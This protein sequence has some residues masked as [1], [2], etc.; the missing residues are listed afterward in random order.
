MNGG[1]SWHSM[2]SVAD[3]Q[4]VVHILTATL[5]DIQNNNYDG[6]KANSMAS[7]FEKYTFMKSQSKE[8]YLRIIKLKIAQ[9]RGQM[10]Q[11][12]VQNSMPMN[13]FNQ[14]PQQPQ[15][16]QA[17]QQSQPQS[18]PPP[19]P[20][21]AQPPPPQGQ[22]GVN[23]GSGNPPSQQTIQQI[24]AM[25][26]TAPIP[27]ALLAKIP[28]LPPNTNTWN[29][30]F[31]CIN[32]KLIPPSAMGAIKEIHNTHLQVA[33]RQHHQR[34]LQPQNQ[35]Q[36]NMN[37]MNMN[38]MNMNNMNNMNMN[39]NMGMNN[40]GMDNNVGGFNI[41]NLTPQQ[42]QQL[43]QRQ[44]KNQSISQPQPQPQPQQQSQP[45]PPHQPQTAPPQPHIQNQNRQFPMAQPSAPIPGQ[46]NTPKPPNFTISPQ[47]ILKYSGEAMM[48]LD[49]LQANGSIQSV[50]DQAQKESFIRKFIMH[51]KTQQWK[52]QNGQITKPQQG[53][54]R[55][56]NNQM[57]GQRPSMNL[58][59]QQMQQM[60][61]QRAQAQAQAQQR[62]IPPNN[63]PNMGQIPQQLPMMNNMNVNPS[64]VMGQ[65]PTMATNGNQMNINRP[66]SVNNG[67]NTGSIASLLP[68]LT[69]DMRLKLRQ[70]IEEVSRNNV[71]LKEVSNLLSQAD[72]NTVRET[73]IKISQ[74]YGN[75]DSIISYFYI[76]TKNIE[77][78]KRLIQMKYMT[79]NIMEGL[80]RGSFLAS[81][82]LA[83][84]LRIQYMKYFDYV[85]E[86][87]SMR[88]QQL[89]QQ[90]PLTS[91]QAPP[92]QM[93]GQS[94]PMQQM[95]QNVV[96]MQN[97]FKPQQQTQS[98]PPQSGHPGFNPMVNQ[99]QWA[100]VPGNVNGVNGPN[101]GPIPV[102]Q[103]LTAP[104]PQP[105][106]NSPL[107]NNNS[108]PIMGLGAPRGKGKRAST[109]AQAG[110]RK[111]NKGGAPTPGALATTP[112]SLANAIKTPNSIPTP[113]VPTGQSNKNT[114]SDQS[115]NYQNKIVNGKLNENAI[116]DIFSSS[117]QNESQD[118][119]LN[120]RRELS[121]QDPEKF[122]FASLSNL[123]E[124]EDGNE[125][126]GLP[127]PSPSLNGKAN[128][129]SPSNE[130]TA[131]IKPEAI[132][133]SF[134][135]VS[136]IKEAVSLDILQACGMS[137]KGVK[138][139]VNGTVKREREDD[140]DLDLLFS[141]KKPK[142]EV[143]SEIDIKPEFDIKSDFGFLA[144]ENID[145][146]MWKDQIIN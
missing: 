65:R 136:S 61:A 83:E 88:R 62:R 115:P 4:K 76:L 138:T 111:S 2:Y 121:N 49:K 63:A 113:Q 29:Q 3:R 8:E 56:G 110:R 27:P 47:D 67:N 33:L 32:K 135:Q 26:R 57:N 90:G 23:N 109:S 1:S 45:Q 79:K 146:A 9:L 50:L 31:D 93:G 102:T 20:T 127:T 35:G 140:D 141:D 17:P 12:M 16:G 75:V 80:Q 28:N 13:S 77:G 37:N 130:W 89:Q 69:D 97:Q 38:N 128:V 55:M 73:M 104:A 142:S 91:Q 143:D 84:K 85:K 44:M 118:F 129:S 95:P 120:K 133:T 30:I 11:G 41:N 15:Q 53:Q 66:Q 119:E 82:D 92:Q 96:Q 21:Q 5:K 6:Q 132:T 105:V 42:K 71:S 137:A 99:N 126:K 139:E 54:A 101:G 22:N 144:D 112:A 72:K 39:M 70:M 51:Q 24:S 125:L 145:F 7:E 100:N 86:Q 34:R 108:S 59:Q 25:I 64:P 122:F 74:Q 60:Q 117:N 103:P 87:F 40:M 94:Q 106:I 18:Q 98:V 131:S 36:N 134:R 123:L 107:M 78:T 43:M 124:I 48:L 19:A 116:G 10:R 14:A 46:N 52:Q 68:P 81:P 114:P 58:N